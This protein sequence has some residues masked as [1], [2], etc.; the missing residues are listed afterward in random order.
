MIQCNCRP[1]K[2]LS[3]AKALCTS[4]ARPTPANGWPCASVSWWPS[5]FFCPQLPVEN[6]ES[7]QPATELGSGVDVLD[8]ATKPGWF[9][10][11]TQQPDPNLTVWLGVLP[12]QQGADFIPKYLV[13]VILTTSPSP[14]S[15]WVF[16]ILFLLMTTS[17]FQLIIQFKLEIIIFAAC[18]PGS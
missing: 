12:T 17:G 6:N 16:K 10:L 15:T 4:L 7:F 13:W 9:R 11:L 14:H 1:N 8:I 5:L 18:Q 3:A 2:S